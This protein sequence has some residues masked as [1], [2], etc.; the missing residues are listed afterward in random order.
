M[1]NIPRLVAIKNV[2]L[3][4]VSNIPDQ[5]IRGSTE[6]LTVNVRLVNTPISKRQHTLTRRA[7]TRGQGS[8]DP[9][10]PSNNDIEARKTEAGK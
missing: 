7:L 4:T 5:K 3:A 10:V 8:E 2:K 1:L 6:E 9:E